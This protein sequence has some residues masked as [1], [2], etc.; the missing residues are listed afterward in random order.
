LSRHRCW[1]YA[2]WSVTAGSIVVEDATSDRDSESL[3]DSG[4]EDYVEK[5][6][7]HAKS[8]RVRFSETVRYAPDG[9]QETPMS[10]ADTLDGESQGSLADVEYASEIPVSGVLT[11]KEID[12]RMQYSL[13]FSQDLLP[14]VRQSSKDM[15]CSAS[16]SVQRRS[17]VGRGKHKFSIKDDDTIIRMKEGVSEVWFR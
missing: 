8:R 12:G 3:D 5:P 16:L 1:P 2:S 13:T 14:H 15:R 9:L 17:R 7:P 10:P 4:D 11:L 6:F